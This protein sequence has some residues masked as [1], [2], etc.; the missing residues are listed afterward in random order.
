MNDPI[1]SHWRRLLSGV[2]LF[3]VAVPVYA[4]EKSALP[5]SNDGAVATFLNGKIPDAIAKGKFNLN[6]RARYENADQE[7]GT[8]PAHAETIRTRFGYTTAPLYGFQAMIEAENVTAANKD[9]Y[10]AGAGSPVPRDIIADPTGTEINQVWLGYTYSDTNFTASVRGGRQMI[11]L[12][13]A[14]FIGNVGWRQNAQTFD[15]AGFKVTP[16]KNLDLSYN[17]LWKVHRIFGD[18]P[19]LAPATS[20][21]NSASHLF[22]AAYTVAPLAKVVG[23]AYLLDLKNERGGSA[24]NSCATYGGY[25]TGTWT[26]DQEHQGAVSYRGEFAWQTDYADNPADYETAYY[27]GELKATYDRFS[28]SVGYEAL[29]SDNAQGFRTPLATLHAFNGWADV[30]STTPTTG[31]RDFYASAGVNLPL[32]IP[33]NF[34]YHKFDADTGGADFGQEYDLVASRK[35][36]KNWTVLAKYAKYDGKAAPFAFDKQ[37]FWAEIEF[38]F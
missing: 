38:N 7:G 6:V 27:L 11:V 36:G 29:G 1:K 14:R 24:V 26:F 33:V 34:V 8:P 23:Y 9:T 21:F 32:N 30:F 12:D 13:N 20:D 2:L 18:D 5:D 22:N 17:Y 19:S 4:E 15:A 28:L 16:I 35:F 25:L 31:L 37:V 3:A 10:A